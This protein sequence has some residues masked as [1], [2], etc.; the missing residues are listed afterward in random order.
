MKHDTFRSDDKLNEISS[1]SSQRYNSSRIYNHT[2]P[3]INDLID[4]KKKIQILSN[5]EAHLRGSIRNEFRRQ[6]SEV[7]NLYRIVRSGILESRIQ[8]PPKYS[9]G[10]SELLLNNWIKMKSLLII[11]GAFCV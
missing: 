11:V 7:R 3:N 9:H 6:L 5:E 10:R 8:M 4:V 1:S 2:L